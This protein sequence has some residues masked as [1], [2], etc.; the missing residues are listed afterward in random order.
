MP[1]AMK[2]NTQLLDRAYVQSKVI[3]TN[4]QHLTAT[5]SELDPKLRDDVRSYTD[6]FEQYVRRLGDA[7]A[8]SPGEL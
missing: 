6:R 1:T 4:L 5:L 7:C 8:R 3:E 2:G